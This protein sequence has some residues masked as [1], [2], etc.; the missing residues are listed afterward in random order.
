MTLVA[1]IGAHP[2]DLL[3]YLLY[4]R[5]FPSQNYRIA[6]WTMA[7]FNLRHTIAGALLIIFKCVPVRSDWDESIN[8]DPELIAIGLFHS[9]T[10]FVI[11]DLTHPISGAIA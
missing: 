5:F 1:L 2:Q 10:D 11:L 7:A 9:Y 6:L 8:P 4:R 3:T